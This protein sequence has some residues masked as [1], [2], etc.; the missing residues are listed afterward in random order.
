MSSQDS[1][2]RP[3]RA[4]QATEFNRWRMPEMNEEQRQK[5]VALAR[6]ISPK[7][8]L[9]E[10]VEIVEEPLVA[11]KLTVT[12][13]ERIREEARQEG[14]AQG[15]EEG[16]VEGLKLGQEQGLAKGLEQAE[17]R[18]Q[19]QLAEVKL[20]V[21]QLQAPLQSQEE[22]LHQLLLKLVVRVSSALVEAEF[23][24]RSDL[25]LDTIKQAIELIPPGSETPV[26]SLNPQDRE[27]VQPLA[28]LHGWE[29]RDKPDAKRGD[30]KLI[31]GG[32]IIDSSLEA[33]M[34]QVA[35]SLLQR[36]TG[37]SGDVAD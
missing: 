14:L 35:G 31:A 7:T 21:D 23:A 37:E 15:R 24:Q 1:K 17:S 30:I 2:S 5:L 13:W 27:L 25:I 33:K 8:S 26:I 4:V 32:C 28:D 36:A 3:I 18:I 20:L 12:E 34:L 6:K 16:R 11:E 22:A 10:S 29:L 19:Q 9:E